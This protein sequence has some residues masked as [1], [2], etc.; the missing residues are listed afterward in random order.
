MGF[1][2]PGFLHFFHPP[3][4]L[5][6]NG[7][8]RAIEVCRP[9]LWFFDSG[10]N[11]SGATA[12][13]TGAHKLLSETRKTT[14]KFRRV[15]T[16]LVFLAASLGRFVQVLGPLVAGSFGRC[17]C[18]ADAEVIGH[19]NASFW[20]FYV[21][22]MTIFQATLKFSYYAKDKLP[23]FVEFSRYGLKGNNSR[24]LQFDKGLFKN[25]IFQ[26][27]ICFVHNNYVLTISR[28]L[29][30]RMAAKLLKCK[31]GIVNRRLH[32]YAFSLNTM[33]FH[34]MKHPK[35][36]Q[37]LPNQTMFRPH[38]R[39]FYLEHFGNAK[40]LYAQLNLGTSWVSI[41]NLTGLSNES[42]SSVVSIISGS[43]CRFF[44]LLL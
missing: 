17:S 27:L 41:Y 44:F 6:E 16:S 4:H 5:K 38:N 24:Y 13:E 32:L 15:S 7:M 29:N 18:T 31:K 19:D 36:H 35:I 21:H 1:P 28:S 30:T 20:S 25:G 23:F 43:P 33:C 22:S 37:N 3:A 12:D 10:P 26:L 14:T 42:I 34:N 2:R 8:P 11:N 40:Y 9:L 39:I